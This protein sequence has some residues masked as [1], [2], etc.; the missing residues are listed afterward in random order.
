M[1]VNV[2]INV[3][4]PSERLHVEGTAKITGVTEITDT[5]QSTAKD[6]GALIVDGGAG[7]GKDVFIGGKADV[8]GNLIVSG[9]AEFQNLV[10]IQ[11]PTWIDSGLIVSGFTT[12]TIST[13]C[14]LYTSP[15]PRD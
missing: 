8:D 7:F 14:L 3:I 5:T 2:G 12:G 11:G 6:N 9:D 15:S 10:T 13:A 4:N 1:G